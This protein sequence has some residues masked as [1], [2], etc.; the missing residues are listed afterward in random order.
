[1]APHPLE[2]EK[3]QLLLLN[4]KTQLLL[5]NATSTVNF[6]MQWVGCYQ[7]QQQS[8]HWCCSSQKNRRAEVEESRAI[9]YLGLGGKNWILFL[10]L[11]QMGPWIKKFFGICPAASLV[12]WSWWF[13]RQWF[14][15]LVFLRGFP[16]NLFPVWSLFLVC[17][18][19]KLIPSCLP[20]L[21]PQKKVSIF[22]KSSNILREGEEREG[23]EQ[24]R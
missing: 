7:K 9:L 4:E 17:W 22:L 10:F 24:G 5:L 6:Q 13:Y 15:I 12:D 21:V 1:M 19:T 23:D 14:L 20:L 11:G 18:P 8:R 2:L 3:T 16:L